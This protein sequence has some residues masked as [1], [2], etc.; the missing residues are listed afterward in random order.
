MATIAAT[1]SARTTG[2]TH[3]IPREK[4]K[5]G[6]G[7]IIGSIVIVAYAII[8][9]LWILSLSLKPESDITDG[10][11][12]PK[13][14]S[15]VNYSTIFNTGVFVRPLINSIGI[16]LI[17]TAIAVVLATLAAYAIARLNFPGKKVVLS[18]ALAI[19]M[20]PPISI[21]GPLFNMWRS[22][23]L[24]DT[25]P[26]LIIPYMTFALPMAI[27]VLSAFFRQIPWELEQAASVDGASPFQA[28]R[29]VIVPLAAPGVFTAAILVFFFCWNDFV[30]SITLTSTDRSRTV[31]A[32]LNFFTGS[33]QF[34]QPTGAI[35]AAAIVV[36]VPI[37][38]M[39]LIFQRR[40]VAGLTSGAVKG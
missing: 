1:G 39:V 35:A 27:W 21:V 37:I 34:S 14:F 16:T 26:G 36:T 5:I 17:S 13:H 24:Y 20:F 4:R 10:A 15:W 18:A 30:F 3:E 11:V 31:P 29:K 38:I 40:I 33:S 8:P 22:L 9:I 28:F 2:R 23:G 32:A 19:A 7:W 25:W 12:I 6:I